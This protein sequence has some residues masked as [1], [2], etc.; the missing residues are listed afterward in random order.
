M[1]EESFISE[2]KRLIPFLSFSAVIVETVIF[3]PAIFIG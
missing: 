3:I 1:V 2:R